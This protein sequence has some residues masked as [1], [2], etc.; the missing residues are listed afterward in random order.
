[1]TQKWLVLLH[2]VGVVLFFSNTFA[3]LF[4]MLRAARSRDGAVIAHTF[5]TLMDTDRLITPLSVVLIVVTGIMASI[6][7]GFGLLSTGWILWS[8]IALLASG[9][10]FVSRLLPLQTKIA[11]WTREAAAHNPFD[12]D[13][14]RIESFQ[15]AIWAFLSMAASFV[16]LVLMV[17]KPDLPALG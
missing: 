10:I 7:G 9:V 15:W 13:R 5:R 16:G 12:W 2:I 3:A 8:T 17:L 14:Y 1:M 4:W 6:R 11:R